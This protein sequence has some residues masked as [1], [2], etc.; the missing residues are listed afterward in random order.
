MK[1]LDT[2]LSNGLVINVVTSEQKHEW[3][4]LWNSYMDLYPGE[5]SSEL[6]QANW[7]RISSSEERVFAALGHYNGKAVALVH[8]VLHRSTWGLTFDCYINDLYVHDSARGLGFA[9]LMIEFV[10]SYAKENQCRKLY[11]VTE[12]ENTCAQKLYNRIATKSSD[13]QYEST[14]R[15]PI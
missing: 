10:K 11:W 3:E 4:F 5:N 1:A 7:S 8:W 6:T 15:D 2:C 9:S 14:L 13:I 12:P